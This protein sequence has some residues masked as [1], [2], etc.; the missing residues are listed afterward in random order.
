LTVYADRR[1]MLEAVRMN[2]SRVPANGARNG[3]RTSP[4]GSNERQSPRPVLLLTSAGGTP[5]VVFSFSLYMMLGGLDKSR[6]EWREFLPWA[7]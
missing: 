6:G 7:E 2:G 5:A 3:T 4:D 1:K